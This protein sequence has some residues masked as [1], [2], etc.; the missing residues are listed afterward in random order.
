MLGVAEG[1]K[2]LHVDLLCD[3]DHGAQGFGGVPETPRILRQHVA[4]YGLCQMVAFKP[5]ACTPEH[6]IVGTRADQVRTSRP[7]SPFRCAE[8]EKALGIG[9]RLM[10]RPSHIPGDIR[11][12]RVSV[13]DYGCV[14]K[15]RRRQRESSRFDASRSF[16]ARHL[17]SGVRA[18]RSGAGRLQEGSLLAQKV[19]GT[20]V[21]DEMPLVVGRGL[22]LGAR[23]S[24][25]DRFDVIEPEFDHPVE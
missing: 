23:A 5:E 9:N 15:R 1:V 8:S 17:C 14:G 11:I 16:H 24:P 13:E 20:A 18:V 2:T 3:V 4:G 19:R 10:P 22:P 21:V 6:S 12:A 7:P 25:E